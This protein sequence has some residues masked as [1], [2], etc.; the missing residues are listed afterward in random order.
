MS[1]LGYPVQGRH[2]HTGA[3]TAEG[4]QDDQGAGML[5]MLGC[6]SSAFRREDQGENLI[7]VGSVELTRGRLFIVH[8]GSMRGFGHKFQHG[9]LQTHVRKKAFKL[10]GDQTLDQVTQVVE[11]LSLEISRTQWPK[12]VNNLH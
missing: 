2:W 1:S 5:L 8:S 6:V 10:E 9:R 7:A 4:Y 12:A 11:F 3:S